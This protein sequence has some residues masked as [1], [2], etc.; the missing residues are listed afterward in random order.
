MMANYVSKTGVWDVA[1]G[2]TELPTLTVENLS[3]GET[4][5]V[6]CQFF[7]RT[8]TDDLGD[9]YGYRVVELQGAL[10]TLTPDIGLVQGSDS[11]QLF[12][13]IVLFEVDS[14]I[15]KAEFKLNISK[16]DMNGQ[17]VMMN[18]MLMAEVID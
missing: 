14:N 4:M 11:W 16:G 5:K 2:E 17:G 10:I 6:T 3:Q 13:H 15:E 18:Y 1:V 8:M 9:G 12:T 7:G